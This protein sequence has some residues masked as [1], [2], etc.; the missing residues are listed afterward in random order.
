MQRFHHQ[1][2]QDLAALLAALNTVTE[3]YSRKDYDTGTALRALLDR[4]NA[5]YKDKGLPD[6]ESQLQLLRAEWSAAEKGLDPCTLEKVTVRRGEMKQSV[7]LKVLRGLEAVLRE[8]YT[9]SRNK[10]E[11]AAA[12]IG[13]IIVAGFQEGIIDD[14][15]LLSVNTEAEYLQLWKALGSDRNIALGQKRVLTMVSLPDVF[16]LLEEVVPPMVQGVAKL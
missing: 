7:M 15:M 9:A 14:R 3:K 4:A 12:M 1:I 13:Q 6:R 10:L 16:L 5:D 8:D 2:R 11:E